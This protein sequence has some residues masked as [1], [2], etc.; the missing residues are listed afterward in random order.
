MSQNFINRI[1]EY[2]EA[3]THYY[4]YAHRF[5]LSTTF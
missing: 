2:C 4:L 1:C 5:A 3:L